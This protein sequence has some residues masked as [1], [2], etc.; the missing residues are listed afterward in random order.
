MEGV[1]NEYPAIGRKAKVSFTAI[2]YI[3]HLIAL[4]N[5]TLLELI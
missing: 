4:F 3:L 2:S 5:N 1:E